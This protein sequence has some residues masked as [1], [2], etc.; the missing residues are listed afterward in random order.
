MNFTFSDKKSF[1]GR[2]IGVPRI[3]RPHSRDELQ[4]GKHR[5]MD[6]AE[7]SGGKCQNRLQK[8][9]QLFRKFP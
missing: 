9:Y 8:G 3:A 4:A 5:T 7:G 1:T 6:K 2:Q